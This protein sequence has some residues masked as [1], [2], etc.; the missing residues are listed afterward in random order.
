M[1]GTVEYAFV[2]GELIVRT[3]RY[4]VVLTLPLVCW[5]AGQEC[6]AQ[7]LVAW[8]LQRGMR[9][10]ATPRTAAR[11]RENFDISALPGDALD[12]IN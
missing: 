9:L 8:A 7:A 6:P 11:A 2:A 1:K 4:L 12:E 10:L 3:G 5:L